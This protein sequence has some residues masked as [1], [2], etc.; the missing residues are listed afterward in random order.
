MIE[1]VEVYL[2]DV[3]HLQDLQ[4]V[5]STNRK[6]ELFDRN[7]AI[8]SAS[9]PPHLPPHFVGRDNLRAGARLKLAER[10]RFE[11]SMGQ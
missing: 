3:V 5:V 11:L 10:E 2:L 6:V 4:H 1:S 9:L 8:H 7:P